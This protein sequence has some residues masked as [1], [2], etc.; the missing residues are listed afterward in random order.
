MFPGRIIVFAGLFI[1]IAVGYAGE[2]W[3]QAQFD[4]SYTVVSPDGGGKIAYYPRA[5]Y[6]PIDSLNMRLAGYYGLYPDNDQLIVIGNYLYLSAMYGFAVMDIGSNPHSPAI[7]ATVTNGPWYISG[8]AAYGNYLYVIQTEAGLF[9]YD[10]SNPQKPSVASH[11]VL[12]EP[13]DRASH[14]V[15]VGNNLYLVCEDYDYETHQKIS[16]LKVFSLSKPSQPAQVSVLDLPGFTQVDRLFATDDSTLVI[17]GLTPLIVKVKISD[18]DAPSISAQH[19]FSDDPLVYLESCYYDT[20]GFLYSC[21]IQFDTINYTQ[22]HYRLTCDM[23]DFS[24]PVIIDSSSMG[25]NSENYLGL[26]GKDTLIVSRSDTIIFCDIS[27]PGVMNRIAYWYNG[28]A[29][30]IQRVIPNKNDL[31]TCGIFWGLHI[32]D[33]SDISNINDVYSTYVGAGSPLSISA[34]KEGRVFATYWWTETDYHVYGFNSTTEGQITVSDSLIFESGTEIS[35][36]NNLL[37]IQKDNNDITLFDVTTPGKYDSVGRTGCTFFRYN[38]FNSEGNKLYLASCYHWYGN[39]C[40]AVLDVSNPASCSLLAM[41]NLNGPCCDICHHGSYVYVTGEDTATGKGYLE[42]YSLTGSNLEK[43]SSIGLDEEGLGLCRVGDRLYL[44][45]YNALE[46]FDL[47]DPSKPAF[48]GMTD[49]IISGNTEILGSG[50][51]NDDVIASGNRVYVASDEELVA[52]DV[53]DPASPLVVGYYIIPNQASWTADLRQRLR[54]DGNLIYWSTMAYGICVIDPYADAEMVAEKPAQNPMRLGLDVNQSLGQGCVIKYT[55][56]FRSNVEISVYDA[57]GRLVEVLRAA[58]ET[59]GTHHFTW[60]ADGVSSGVY[61]VRLATD[62]GSV[63]T[64]LL[65]L[66]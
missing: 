27:T 39:G 1:M 10:V 42:T 65:V 9:T 50:G 19:S 35:H 53:T 14:G 17:A 7:V 62:A 11:I 23:T 18:P 31:L 21:F 13:F 32:L 41:K 29:G 28:S 59:A 40:M 37:G 52:F 66:D 47:S 8:F 16:Q 4:D 34:P 20:D 33:R 57:S 25:T 61:F 6:A 58:R 26:L 48:L 30:A 54:S 56:P 51:R 63:T 5:A 46:I 43:T 15:V 38:R 60:D 22:Y 55:L 64:K 24:N 36:V 12:P 49:S 3:S 45:R 44:S 2:R